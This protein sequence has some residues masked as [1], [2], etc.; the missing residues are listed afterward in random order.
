MYPGFFIF[1]LYFCFL[2]GVAY[3]T[4]AGESA[5][6]HLFSNNFVNRTKNVNYL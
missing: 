1:H 3:E 6:N 2:Y 4:K 5:V